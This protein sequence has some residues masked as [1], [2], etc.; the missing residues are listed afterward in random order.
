MEF[1]WVMWYEGE[2][3][4]SVGRLTITT[5]VD[6]NVGR[7]IDR[8]GWGVEIFVILLNSKMKVVVIGDRLG[9]G[10]L[11]IRVKWTGFGQ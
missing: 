2:R 8:S 5:Q 7:R 9:L 3:G 6:A 1:V 4:T 11:L 10:D